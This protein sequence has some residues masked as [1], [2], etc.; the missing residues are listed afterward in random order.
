M[1]TFKIGELEASQIILGCMRIKE[2]GKDPVAVLK[3]QLKKELISLTMRISMVVELV[4]RFLL[5]P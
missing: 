3:L 4:N 2:K 1:K 5:M